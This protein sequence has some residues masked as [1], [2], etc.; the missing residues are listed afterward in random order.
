MSSQQFT[1]F[2]VDG[3]LFGI[4]V[5]SVQEVLRSQPMTTVPL[6]APAVGGLINLRG[7]VIPAVDVRQRLAPWSTGRAEHPVNVVVRTES[8]PV[9]LLVD[10]IGAVVDA[11]DDDFE[12]PPETLVGPA[13]A[14]IR[15]AYKLDTALLL[16]LDVAGVVTLAAS[17]D[18]L[19][20]PS[21]PS[22][23]GTAG[24]G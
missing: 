8:G 3:Q 1:T 5:E 6:A 23:K 20:R 21:S 15:G 10:A 18:G 19:T 24:H 12:P 14:L 9:S 13:R 17:S 11:Q 4:E 2:L 7:E 16:A 22:T